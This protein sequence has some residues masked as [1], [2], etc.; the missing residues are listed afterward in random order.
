MSE[1]LKGLSWSVISYIPPPTPTPLVLSCAFRSCLGPKSPESICG[2]IKQGLQ[3]RGAQAKYH[4]QALPTSR[5]EALVLSSAMLLPSQPHEGGGGEKAVEDITNS[6]SEAELTKRTA[7]L[8]GCAIGGAPAEPPVHENKPPPTI[9]RG[10]VAD[11]V[12]QQLPAVR[13]ARSRKKPAHRQKCPS[14]SSGRRLERNGN[15]DLCVPSSSYLGEALGCL[16]FAP[17]GV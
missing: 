2:L 17:G 4:A 14:T 3:D 10:V 12:H 9:R 15:F 13:H 16:P 7:C 1:F 11:E 6:V 5:P 8:R